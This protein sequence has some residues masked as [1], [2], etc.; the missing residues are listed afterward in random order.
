MKY[1]NQSGR[2]DSGGSALGDRVKAKRIAAGLTLTQLAAALDVSR[3]YL[4]RLERGEYA[5]PSSQVLS[6]IIKW[7]GLSV[8]DAYALTGTMLP[9]D[10]PSF[11]PYVR[12]KHADWPEHA[13][14][15]LELLYDYIK[16]KYSLK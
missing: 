8:E 2:P 10:L 9:N 1:A 7:M 6:R 14:R 5:H 15:E 4:S 13:C 12:A 16:Y 11:G 3:P